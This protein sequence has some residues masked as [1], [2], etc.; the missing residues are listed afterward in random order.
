MLDAMETLPREP[1]SRSSVSPVSSAG[2]HS[3]EFD[4]YYDNEDHGGEAAGLDRYH[5]AVDENRNTRNGREPPDRKQAK[6]GNQPGQGDLHHATSAV[7]GFPDPRGQTCSPP[8]PGLLPVVPSV[9][10]PYCTSLSAGVRGFDCLVTAGVGVVGCVLPVRCVWSYVRNPACLLHA[11][12]SQICRVE[13]DQI[14]FR[15]PRWEWPS[16]INSSIS[17]SSRGSHTNNSKCAPLRPCG[18]N[19]NSDGGWPNSSSST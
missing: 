19:W 4:D 17:S 12:Y 11:S 18:C 7:V 1:S 5:D 9:L 13:H 8:P 10:A 2:S 16:S 15:S 14:S 6:A 3:S